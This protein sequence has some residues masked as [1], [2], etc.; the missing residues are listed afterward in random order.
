MEYNFSEF[1]L[2][3]YDMQEIKDYI[4][5]KATLVEKNK[6]LFQACC[7]NYIEIVNF[8][9]ENGADARTVNVELT[10]TNAIQNNDEA[11]EIVNKW[12]L[13]EKLKSL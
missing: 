7:D 10:K 6:I 9:L 5:T 8:S 2:E 1:F 11:I 3:H 13:I 12:L 4:K